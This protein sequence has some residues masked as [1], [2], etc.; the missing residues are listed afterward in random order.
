MKKRI[1]GFNLMLLLTVLFF[2]SCRD[3]DCGELPSPCQQSCE[4]EPPMGWC[5]TGAVFKYYFN[6]N[7]GACQSYIYVGGDI[8][9]E[10]LADCEACACTRLVGGDT[11]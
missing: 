3:I 2:S 10:T 1:L 8:P 9:F 4:M 7:T 11:P 5:G 6:K